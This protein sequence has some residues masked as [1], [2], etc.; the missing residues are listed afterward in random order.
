M[1]PKRSGRRPPED[2]NS[3]A[4]QLRAHVDSGGMTPHELARESGVDSGQLYRFLSGERGIT[5]DTAGRLAKALGLKLVETGRARRG[6]SA[7]P[8]R[9]AG[10]LPGRPAGPGVDDAD[11]V[12]GEGLGAVAE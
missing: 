10:Q 7:V 5:L 12:E 3:L 2:R 1:P 9:R 11:P 8:A 6:R 4:N